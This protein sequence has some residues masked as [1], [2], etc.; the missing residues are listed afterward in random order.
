MVPGSV[1]TQQETI[2]QDFGGALR[3]VVDLLCANCGS[4]E[5]G[6]DGKKCPVARSDPAVCSRPFP[7]CRS[8]ICTEMQNLKTGDFPEPPLIAPLKN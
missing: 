1:A 5:H 2:T 6:W 8:F 3:L 7:H 4:R